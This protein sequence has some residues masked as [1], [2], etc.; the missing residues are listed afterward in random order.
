MDAIWPKYTKSTL[1][2]VIDNILREIQNKKA[3]CILGLALGTF[4]DNLAEEGGIKTTTQIK[5][6]FGLLG[7][8]RWFLNDFVRFTKPLT[9]CLKKGA[10]LKHNHKFISCF[11]TCMNLHTYE[12]I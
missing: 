10:K 6:F 7:Y 12:P 2:L 9:E 8:Y 3:H 11:E 1:Q 5:E 4:K